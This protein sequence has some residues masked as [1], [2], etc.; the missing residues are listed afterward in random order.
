MFW[1]AASLILWGCDSFRKLV[2]LS[3]HYA[4]QACDSFRKLVFLSSHY[5]EQAFP[6]SAE[7]GLVAGDNKGCFPTFN[8][9]TRQNSFADYCKR[10]RNS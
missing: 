1:F 6:N 9:H 8:Y 10:Q 2:S 4:E 7:R 3:S 5:A